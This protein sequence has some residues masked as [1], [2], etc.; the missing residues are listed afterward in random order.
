MAKRDA[1][2]APKSWSS[3]LDK[4]SFM[5]RASH[6]TK[7]VDEAKERAFKNE[8]DHWTV[9][10]S[11]GTGGCIVIVEGDPPHSAPTS[12][13]SFQNF[14]PATEKLQR[15]LEGQNQKLQYIRELGE[16]CRRDKI[17]G[18]EI[19][20]EEMAKRL[21]TV[22]LVLQP[23]DRAWEAFRFWEAARDIYPARRP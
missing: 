13:M 18:A 11:H 21:K 22:D 4:L 16:Q 9:Q 23:E 10:P 3:K 8:E 12:R 6:K 1:A 20:A 15:E 7:L 19:S 5:R 2:G 14:N 17:S